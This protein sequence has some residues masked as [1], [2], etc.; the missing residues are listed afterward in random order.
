MLKSVLRFLIPVLSLV[1]LSFLAACDSDISGELFENLAPDT[2][3]SVRDTSLV[4]NRAGLGRFPSSVSVS[5]SGTDPDGFVASFELRVYDRSEQHTIGPEEGWGSTTSRDSVILLPIPFGERI[6]DVVIEARAVDNLGLKDPSPSRTVFPV[7]NGPPSLRLSG[8]DIPPDETFTVFSFGWSA[9]DPEGEETI[10]RIEIS[11]NDSL[12]FVSLPGNTRFATFLGQLDDNNPGETEVEA[13]VFTGRGFLPADVFVP[14]LR[15]DAENTFYVRAADQTDTT[16]ATQQYQWNVRRPNGDILFV[17]DYRKLTEPIVREFHLQLLQ[18]YLP[19][20]TEVEFYD[21]SEPYLSGATTSGAL[22]DALPATA[23]PTLEQTFLLFDYIYWLSTGVTAT[24]SGNNLAFAAPALNAFF[25]NGGKL[26]IHTPVQLP[27]DPED[28]VTNPA[29]SLLPLTDVITFPDS[30]RPSLRLPNNGAITPVAVV[31]GPDV[32]LPALSANR[33]IIRTLP[34]V[35]GGNII[36]LYEAEYQYQ[37]RTGGGR[38]IWAGPA[39]VASMSSDLRVALM[40]V[41]LVSES[42]GS[43]QLEGAD[44]SEN[45]AIDAMNLILESLEFPKR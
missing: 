40:A 34:Y 8:F 5:W 43:I 2:E 16:S 25:S 18:D 29:I 28:F 22:S 20:G 11:L 13:E 36:P 23:A 41:P 1:A 39:T 14:G 33:L 4:E 38:G 31:P 35:I 6:A 9:F 32:Q 45:A 27:G 10:A 3:L 26:M 21:I 24:T 37:T 7:E 12:N 15:L 44:G 17:S 42:D 30:L 19:E